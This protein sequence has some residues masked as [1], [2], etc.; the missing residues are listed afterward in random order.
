MT[1]AT[2]SDTPVAY[3]KNSD[4]LGV[5]FARLLYVYPLTF[6][7]RN[8]LTALPAFVNAFVTHLIYLRFNGVQIGFNEL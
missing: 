8:L 1:Y 3:I 7:Y 5:F 6:L 4:R 2:V